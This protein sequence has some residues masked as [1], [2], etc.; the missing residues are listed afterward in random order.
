MVSDMMYQAFVLT[1]SLTTNPAYF[2][3]AVVVQ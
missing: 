2:P 3:L 1:K